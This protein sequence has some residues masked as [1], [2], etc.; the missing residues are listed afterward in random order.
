MQPQTRK[1]LT[2]CWLVVLVA[3]VSPFALARVV[4]IGPLASIGWFAS[5]PLSIVTFRR[6]AH[7]QPLQRPGWYRAA[8]GLQRAVTAVGLVTAGHTVFANGSIGL[9]SIATVQLVVAVLTWRAITQPDPRRAVLA[10]IVSGCIPFVALLVDIALD[11][12]F[13]AMGKRTV[14]TDLWSAFAILS[15]MLAWISGGIVCLATIRTFGAPTNLP[16]ARAV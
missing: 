15:T 5:I 14:V 16:D 4:N 9:V 1:T 6:C 12:H 7:D 10:A 8:L 11:L 13:S 2:I 3:M